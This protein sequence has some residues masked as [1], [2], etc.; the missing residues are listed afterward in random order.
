M[1]SD[2]IYRLRALVRRRAVESEMND[3]LRFHFE[4][5][6]EKYVSAGT[7]RTDAERRARM[8]FG[9]VESVKEECRE[10]RGVSTIETTAQ[11]LRYAAR[12]LRK[13]PAFSVIA[14][15]TLALG[16]GANTAI[17]SVI[18]AVM[19][20]PLPY[21]DPGRLMQFQGDARSG[22]LSVIDSSVT[23][24]DFV[25]WKSQSRAFD[26][27]AAYYRPGGF[28]RVTLTG[29]EPESVQGGFV[30]SDFFPVMGIAPILGRW[31]TSRE[32]KQRDRV[33]VLSHVLWMRRFGGSSDAVG[34]TLEIDGIGARVIGVMPTTFQF[35][36][37][38]VQFWMPVT[39]NRTWGESNPYDPVH[40]RGN[41]ARWYLVGRLGDGMAIGRAQ[42]E[43]NAINARLAQEAPD[44]DRLSNIRV[45]PFHV[46]LSDNTRLAIYVLFA[47]VCCVLLI[48][49]SNA[50]NLVLARG[51]GRVREMAVRT[52]LGAGR[53]R[54]VR[55][56]FTE[57]AVLALLSGGLGLLLAALG[58]RA[59]VAHAPAD[60]YRL[61]Q[62]GIDGGVL[63]FV[64]AVSL[65]AAIL[66]GLAPAWT[67][68]RTDPNNSLKSGTRGATSAVGLTRTR[69]LLVVAEFALSVVLLTGAGLL[70]RSFLAVESVNPGFRPEHLATMHI[71]L[72]AGTS[73]AR[74][75]ELDEMTLARVRAIPGVQAVG[76]IDGLFERQP[77]D[78]GLRAVDG[79]PPEPETR[80]DPL[81]WTSIR[82]DYFQAMGS[83]LL[84]GKM[85]TEQA[86]PESPLVAIVDQ[87]MAK[88]YWPQED[89]IGKRIKGFDH[90]GKNDDWVTII[91]VVEDMRR[92][93][94]EQK[95]ASHV[96]E[97]YRQSGDATAD[98]IVRTQGD[99]K[100]LA[101]TLRS[102]VR[103]LDRTAI[104]SSVVT[105]EQ[106][107]ADQLAPRRFQTWLLT[108]FSMMAVVLASVGI[109]GVMH[110]S[111][112]QRTHEIGVRMALGAR[113]GNVVRM[114]IGQGIMLAVMGLG[115]GMAGAW[116]LTRQLASLLFGVTATDP[117]TF[118]AVAIV[119]TIV[120]ILASAIPAMRAAR[121]DPLTALRCD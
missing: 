114:V 46:E 11:D 104:L 18:E 66:F 3:E 65:L 98:L 48:A 57:S 94:R 26:N 100:A 83:R 76:A 52:A 24:T 58:I 16:I 72:P 25:A 33:V 50:A 20:R 12:T 73:D 59:L 110:Y 88:R 61:D 56:L 34:R 1:W 120:A 111:V 96:Y 85:F 74:R 49:C 63:G 105:V 47:A 21:K 68:S 29:A 113:P 75:R 54:L 80:W 9:G 97:W 93:G 108:L 19:L 102:V 37:R 13:S 87:S 53:G 92:H 7:E 41:W 106:E 38:D 64:V 119:L 67:I 115:A 95:I 71:G 8:E 79:R 31:F 17:F 77:E 44:R 121:V 4:R 112:A 90:R 51:A 60:I 55:Q 43:L 28:T 103:S 15:A 22:P 117:V 27:V 84:R 30:S 116:W 36:S 42:T 99:P 101:A 14:V 5:Q 107:L 35:P 40:T 78:F 70:V 118:V 6:V 32:E 82:G 45:L 10:A 91:G 86:G 2:L 81:V 39:T 62:A 69:G 89:P 109:Y 23:Y